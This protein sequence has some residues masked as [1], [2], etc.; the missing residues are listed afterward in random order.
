MDR[1]IVGGAF[2]RAASPRRAPVWWLLLAV[3]FWATV[4][5]ANNRPPRLHGTRRSMVDEGCFDRR[6]Q[7][8]PTHH[9]RHMYHFDFPHRRDQMVDLAPSS[10]PWRLTGR[11]K[12]PLE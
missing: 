6:S 12:S 3:P 1:P 7:P 10:S 9:H 5:Y 8:P 2:Q 4:W 11:L